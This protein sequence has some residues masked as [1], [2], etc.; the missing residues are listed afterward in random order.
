MELSSPAFGAN[1]PIPANHTVKGAGVTPPLMIT[2]VPDGTASLA[3]IVHDP[4]APS[5]DFTHWIIWN[6]SATASVLPENHIPTGAIEGVNDFG[7]QGYGAPAP[8]SGTHRYMFDVYAL[9]I[10]LPLKPG[11]SL[12]ELQAA[13]EGHI[14]TQAQLVG[15]VTA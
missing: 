5:G 2:N 15:T 9:N 3:I 12:R 11:A 4:D 7:K 6:I 10:E 13:M 14:L 8:P 1:Q